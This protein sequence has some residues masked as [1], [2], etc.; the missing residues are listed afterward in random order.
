MFK[1]DEDTFF[2]TDIVKYLLRYHQCIG[3]I[4]SAP[5]IRC[6]AWKQSIPLKTEDV[7]EEVNSD[8]KVIR[9]L[10]LS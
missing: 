3:P 6:T 10:H 1:D 8:G 5:G 7:P 2:I 9:C 4:A